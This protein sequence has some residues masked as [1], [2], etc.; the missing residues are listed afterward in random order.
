M[1]ASDGEYLLYLNDDV[2]IEQED[3]LDALLE[4]AARPEVGVVG[5]QLLYPDR[6]VQHA[7]MF[8]GDG[9]GRHAFRFNASNDPGYFGLAL[10]Q[11]NVIAVT[12]ACMLMRR[13]FFE[14][15]GGFDEAYAVINSDLDFCLRAHQAGKLIVYTPHATLIHHELVT[16][17]KHRLADQDPTQ[18]AFN[19]GHF[20]KRWRTLFAVGDPYFSSRLSRHSDDYR[21][22]D[23]QT[24]SIFA[25]H[26]MFRR[27]SIRRILVVKLDHI[28]D[29]VTALP[30]IRK[31]KTSFPDAR[32]TL[33]AGQAAR[34][35][36]ALEPAIDEFIEFEFF[37]PRSQ[38]GEMNLT[39]E[40]FARLETLL[41]KYRFDL[42]ID[43]RQH[44]ATREVL[45]YTG[46]RIL[47]GYD[48]L[49]RFPFLDIALEW[50]GDKA[51][52]R[53]R[54]HIVDDL[55]A[56]VAAVD[57]A[58]ATG[59]EMLAVAPEPI[60]L[61]SLPEPVQAL[62]ARPVV[63]VHPGA[64]NVTKLWPEKHFSALIDLIVEHDGVSVLLV[65]GPDDA[66]VA[67]TLM[68]NA[69]LPGRVASV[70]GSLP[71]EDLP[72]LLVRCALYIG[73]DTGPK[74]IAAALGIPTIGVHSGVVDATAWG[75]MGRRAVALQRNMRCSPCY[76]A[77]A[78]DCPRQLACLRFLEPSAVH[79]LVEMLLARPVTAR[80]A[81]PSR[82]RKAILARPETVSHGSG[83]RMR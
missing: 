82:D 53:K 18:D 40:D 77:R 25:G 65:G 42:A 63:A 29:V 32:I 51:L 14:D 54:S 49:G 28:G 70:A 46:A 57:A 80:P 56:L 41:H 9:I 22:D 16:L 72:R 74:H 50:D 8:L 67:E 10:T 61:E 27:E 3:W 55:L 45:R 5:P 76:L 71:L 73:N 17:I 81:Q 12:G 26:P 75:P 36:G 69:L 19:S 37:H 13:S 52:H 44:H 78:E 43:L 83:V 60:G 24:R 34:A 11:R 23:E 7:G 6:K 30:A 59:P 64:G 35:L 66:A 4:H 38:L 47:A 1:N 21:P 31:L 48:T 20:E 15:L 33:L 2:E 62:F 68:R 39:K 79:E 58:C